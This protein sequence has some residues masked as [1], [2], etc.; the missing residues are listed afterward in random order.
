MNNATIT[1]L[2]SLVLGGFALASVFLSGCMLEQGDQGAEG[3][4]ISTVSEPLVVDPTIYTWFQGNAS[5]ILGPGSGY[6]GSTHTCFITKVRGN[7][8]GGGEVVRTYISVPASGGSGNWRLGGASQQSGVGAEAI[9]VQ[10]PPMAE[11][12]WNQGEPYA[13]LQTNTA[14]ST[15]CGFTLIK[16]NFAGEGEMLEIYGNYNV[17]PPAWSLGGT[18]LQQGVTGRARC[19]AATQVQPARGSYTFSTGT[20]LYPM[21]TSACVL[22][23]VHGAFRS[24][25]DATRIAKVGSYWQ[26]LKSGSASGAA[27]CG[28]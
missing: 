18:S 16:G 22:G 2:H 21:G 19:I 11:A 24:S 4:S 23:R 15:F 17:S 13:T 9:C 5:T 25:N 14:G 6:S 1:S 26:L 10:K 27:R 7:F 28:I 20:D 3:E 12:V 8:R